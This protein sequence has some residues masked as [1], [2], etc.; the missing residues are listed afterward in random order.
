MKIKSLIAA[1]IFA[2][3]PLSTASAD[4][5]TKREPGIATTLE[6]IQLAQFLE[7]NSG[8]LLMPFEVFYDLN[9]QF[10]GYT[11]SDYIPKGTKL[12]FIVQPTRM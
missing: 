11:L 12:R 8:G 6:R 10:R 4:G 1:A 2:A 9:P 3:L 7:T 5:Q